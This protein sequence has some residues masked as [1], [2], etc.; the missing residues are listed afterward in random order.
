MLDSDKMIILPKTR[1]MKSMTRTLVLL[2]LLMCG[3][4]FNESKTE[5]EPIGVC[6][7][8]TDAHVAEPAIFKVKCATCHTYDKDLMGPKMH[9]VLDKVSEVWLIQF[10]TNQDS[11]IAA[12]DEYTLEIMKWSAVEWNHNFTELRDR[13]KKVLLD[14]IRQ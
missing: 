1:A 6:G 14:Y 5:K 4:C 7:N 11:L 2:C 13:D 3:G 12:G 10:I 9:G 8:A